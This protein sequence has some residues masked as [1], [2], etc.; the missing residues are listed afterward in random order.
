MSDLVNLAMKK[1]NELESS[2]KYWQKE[3]DEAES[4]YSKYSWLW[5]IPSFLTIAIKLLLDEVL[6]ARDNLAEANRNL[7][8]INY[9]LRR[10]QPLVE[11]IQGLFTISASISVAWANMTTATNTAADLWEILESIPEAEIDLA[12][13]T[14]KA[15]DDTLARWDS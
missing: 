14:W 8:E 15:L 1:R 12:R 5:Y 13:K 9:L 11:D 3:L 4:E 7:D 10:L 6:K 2:R